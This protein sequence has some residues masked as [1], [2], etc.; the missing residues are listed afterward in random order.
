MTKIANG[1]AIR[2]NG[3]QNSKQESIGQLN[4]YIVV[5]LINE[6]IAIIAINTIYRA[7]L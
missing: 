4:C 5:V 1:R 6:Y 3:Y 2:A 7:T